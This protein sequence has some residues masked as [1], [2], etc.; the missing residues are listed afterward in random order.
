MKM[1]FFHRFRGG[2]C[3]LYVIDPPVVQ[4]GLCIARFNGTEVAGTYSTVTRLDFVYIGVGTSQIQ[5]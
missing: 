2:V 5:N 3:R 4:F 1:P